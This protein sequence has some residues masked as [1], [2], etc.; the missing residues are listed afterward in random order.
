QP[1][2]RYATGFFVFPRACGAR[3]ICAFKTRSIVWCRNINLCANLFPIAKR[4]SFA[5]A[6]RVVALNP[7]VRAEHV[8]TPTLRA[9]R[10]LRSRTKTKNFLTNP[11]SAGGCG[12]SRLK[13]E[14]KFYGF[15]SA[16]S[17]LPFDYFLLS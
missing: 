6:E 3:L 17:Y 11:F 10:S 9:S 14:R 4:L 8:P 2:R 1:F 5:R 7:I 15:V 12:G 16:A 13:N